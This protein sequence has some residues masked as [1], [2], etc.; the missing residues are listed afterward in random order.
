MMWVSYLWW[1]AYFTSYWATFRL[2]ALSE[3]HGTAGTHHLDAGRLARAWFLP[4]N[5]WL[6]WEHHRHPRV[7]CWNLP[8]LRVLEGTPATTSVAA[9]F[10]GLA[11][12]PPSGFD[13]PD[14]EPTNSTR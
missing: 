14:R 1:W 7:P 6:H 4:H 3:H 12:Y 10:A 5:T 2:R 9:H 13:S 11:G 8:A